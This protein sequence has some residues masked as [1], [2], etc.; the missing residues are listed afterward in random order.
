M[1]PQTEHRVARKRN[2]E[3]PA[4]SR[5]PPLVG[6]LS[7]CVVALYA[8]VGRWSPARLA[9]D[10]EESSLQPRH[11]F[12]L[13]LVCLSVLGLWSRFAAPRPVDKR[14]RWMAVSLFVF[15]GYTVLTAVWAPD[16]DHAARKAADVAI[17]GVATLCVYALLLTADRYAFAT[18]FWVTVLLVG[19]FMAVL[20]AVSGGSARA[21]VLGGGPNVFGRLMTLLCLAALRISIFSHRL[22]TAMACVPVAALAGLLAV[23]SGSR[24]ALAG[25]VAGVGSFL[26]VAAPKSA[27][28][29][30]I[31]LV[32]LGSVLIPISN[33]NV[34]TYARL[35]YEQRIL[36]L[37]LRQRYD[38]QRTSLLA[39]GWEAGTQQP[40]LGLGLSGFEDWP[41]NGGH[42]YPH[43]IFVETF[44]EGGCVGLAMLC[45][46]VILLASIL[47]RNW[48]A[49]DPA[50]FGAF[51]GM[52]VAAQFSGD[53]YDS[54]HVFLFMVW[55]SLPHAYT[56]PQGGPQGTP[57]P[58][59]PSRR[60]TLVPCRFR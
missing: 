18:G 46:T 24:G 29:I 32:A 35:T 57:S 14:T 51:C 49:V 4:A 17:E 8:F 31:L 37:T 11:V 30:A 43:N 25:F 42:R 38:A 7:G 47:A 58:R 48:P 15:L 20:A 3:S 53:L 40:I 9:L 26:V 39:A 27:K 6:G 12:V 50:N 56:H 33:T 1:N 5:I 2:R 10:A 16:S 28:R 60:D 36:E 23:M 54:R 19:G 59:S 34:G 22:A 13:L 55:L 41:S 45:I 21:A 52:L 44:A